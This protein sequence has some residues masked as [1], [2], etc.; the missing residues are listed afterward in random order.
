MYTAHVLHVLMYI[1]VHC[2]YLTCI[3]V[4]ILHV[5]CTCLTCA[6]IYVQ[7]CLYY[8]AITYLPVSG[9]VSCGSAF[10]GRDF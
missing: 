3:N 7:H 4:H 10:D 9:L 5:D 2:T 1:N 6:T 8:D